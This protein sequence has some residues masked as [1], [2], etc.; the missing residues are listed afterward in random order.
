MTEKSTYQELLSAI[1]SAEEYAKVNGRSPKVMR[2]GRKNIRVVE[3]RGNTPDHVP[4]MYLHF[5]DRKKA[6]GVLTLSFLVLKGSEGDS[7]GVRMQGGL[8]IILHSHA[9]NRYI[10]RRRFEGTLKEA[11]MAILDRLALFNQEWDDT[12]SYV[13]YDG[14]VFLGV[15]TDDDKV[16]HLKTFIM[17]RQCYPNERMKSLAAEKEYEDYKKRVENAIEQAK[18]DRTTV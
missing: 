3:W 15:H 16:L 4:A 8:I 1:H 18:N 5:I 12:T 11:T 6:K 17:N 14:G 7:Y 9:I 13:Y 10:E 2:A